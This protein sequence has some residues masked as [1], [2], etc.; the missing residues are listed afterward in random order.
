MCTVAALCL[1]YMYKR[2]VFT[3][4]KVICTLYLHC[5]IVKLG[6][7]C[8]VGDETT[9][10]AAP[11]TVCS[12]GRSICISFTLRT[13]LS[14]NKLTIFDLYECHYQVHNECIVLQQYV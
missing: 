12:L 2:T 8:S 5:H 14:G 3:W 1:I 6:T 4:S 11:N 7:E 10:R 9:Q 13:L